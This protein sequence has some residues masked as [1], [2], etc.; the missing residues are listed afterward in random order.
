MQFDN[1]WRQATV[2]EV[3]KLRDEPGAPHVTFGCSCCG[4]V[5]WSAKNLAL[6]SGGQYTGAR[7][8]FVIN[9]ARGE[10]SCPTSELRCVVEATIP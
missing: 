10:C 4:M 5:N 2:E 8:I 6:S 1:G 7:K 9:W 3:A